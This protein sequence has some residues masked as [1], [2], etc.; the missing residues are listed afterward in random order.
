MDLKAS[1]G[2]DT[3]PA[4]SL[5]FSSR[6]A[7]IA[8]CE[9]SL[10]PRSFALLAALID[11]PGEVVE[12]QELFSLVWGDRIVG[13]AALTQAVSRIR[14][15]FTRCG[16]D[17]E[18]IRTVHGVGYA[19][20]GPLQPDV[21]VPLPSESA[22]T[23]RRFGGLFALVGVVAI[24]ALALWP[25]ER[26]EAT[27]RIAIA[28][29]Q[30]STQ[31]DEDDYAEL[32]LPDL[33]GD[34]LVQRAQLGVVSANRVR[35]GLANL[36]WPDDASEAQ[37]AQMVRELFGVDHVLFARLEQREEPLS[38]AW[39]MYGTESDRP[40]AG[41]A[42]GSGVGGLLSELGESLAEELDVAHAAG[43]PVRRIFSD[44]FVNEAFARGL[45]ALLSGDLPA[46]ERY[47]DSALES[48]PEGGW[49]HYERG[50]ALKL[51]GRFD[52]AA[53]AFERALELAYA[54]SDMNLAGVTETGRGLLDWRESRP[55]A[56][57][58]HFEQ[59][60]EH[61]VAVG[62]RANLASALGNLGIL[63]DNRGELDDARSL[64][65]QA[66]SLYREQGER[67]GESAVYS[68]L[69]VIARKLG[70][71]DRA[72]ELQR[73]ALELQTRTGLRQMTVFS[74]VHLATIERLRGDWEE[75]ARLLDQ[76]GNA[77]ELANDALGRAD[78]LAARAAL[79]AETGDT[80]RAEAA[81]TVAIES[82]AALGNTVGEMLTQLGRGTRL[83]TA[84]PDEARDALERAHSL[85]TN[86]G[87]LD[88]EIW[89]ALRLAQLGE[90]D[91]DSAFE[92]ALERSKQRDPALE[93]AAR[94]AAALRSGRLE[95]LETAF[96]QV[97]RLSRGAREQALLALDLARN[98]LNA[99]QVDDI[100]ALI[101]RAEFWRTDHP[102]TL[103]V[104]ACRE[105]MAVRDAEARSLQARAAQT[106]GTRIPNGWC[107]ATSSALSN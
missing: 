40:S 62:N 57:R 61:F 18:W 41:K 80:T 99:G 63:A 75:S 107:P 42:L 33:L 9:L 93:I 47:F 25:R 38:I 104:R 69:A 43:I 76:A 60:R 100:D 97:R 86:L 106:L 29:F 10:E 92:A 54:S 23:R 7:S 28:P 36:D 84:R 3:Q 52:E 22:S 11:R 95:D 105:A 78:V 12:K 77:V 68:N 90:G 30:S 71:L 37:T 44:E 74:A 59:A 31:A 98:R 16:G 13:D 34:V 39:R 66:L 96:D 82:Y 55:D 56:A 91:F 79:A 27:S 73:L 51:Q 50:N 1:S 45:Q 26:S 58:Q 14:R 24:L 83:L 21:P 20:D 101:G 35:R 48:E 2:G 94:H 102:Q 6:R 32:A 70:E 88:T 4:L 89:A 65:E 17:A 15:E 64:Y 103:A 5:I 85:A 67:A 19:F 72:A 8:D 81:E 87:D 46:A 49:L 53:P